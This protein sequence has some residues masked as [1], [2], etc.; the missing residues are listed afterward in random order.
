MVG[1]SSLERL[2]TAWWRRQLMYMPQEPFFLAGTV[3]E[4]MSM[5]RPD[6]DP[7]ELR[8]IMSRCGLDGFL[9]LSEKGIET[10]L[11]DAGRTLPVGTRKRLALARALAGGGCVALLDEPTEGLDAEGRALVYRAM[12]DMA[13]EGRTIVVVSHDDKIIKGARAVLDLS[14]KP[15]PRLERAEAGEER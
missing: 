14:A 3:R 2:D 9:D 1:G 5:L 7:R 10:P 13:R 12:N 6:A 11:V 8:R 4:N 15:V